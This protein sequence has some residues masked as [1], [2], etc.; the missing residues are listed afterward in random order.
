MAKPRKWQTLSPAYRQ[1]LE[2]G[3]ITRAAYESGAPVTAARGHAKTP[4]RPARA[5]KNPGKY[6][7]YTTK[8]AAKTEEQKTKAALAR[9]L[10][11][12]GARYGIADEILDAIP[13]ADRANFIAGWKLANDDYKRK[14]KQSGNRIAYDQ[15]GGSDFGRQRLKQIDY[16][17]PKA[18][19]E[20]GYYH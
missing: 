12:I 19:I 4:E 15:N 8:N 17:Y 10:K 18:P 1:R 11:K 14:L 7:E 20:A 9:Q 2:R 13:V 6:P 3:G 16:G 5:L